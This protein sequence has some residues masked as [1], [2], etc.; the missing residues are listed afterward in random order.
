[1]LSENFNRM[2][3]QAVY[4]NMLSAVYPNM[5]TNLTCRFHKR[6]KKSVFWKCL[7]SSLFQTSQ[8]VNTSTFTYVSE[9]PQT[10]G[11]VVLA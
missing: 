9:T 3:E 7:S 1:M 11:M 5:A 10:D 4:L 8:R 2:T 6:L